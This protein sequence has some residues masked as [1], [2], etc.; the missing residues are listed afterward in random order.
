MKGKERLLTALSGEK[1][2]QVPTW[3]LAINQPVIRGILEEDA[4]A[5]G[6]LNAYMV[7]AEKLNIEG[8][9]AFEAMN[10]GKVCEE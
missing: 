6:D 3:E 10:Y 5:I 9:T 4:R 8:L 1:P 7:L 2:D